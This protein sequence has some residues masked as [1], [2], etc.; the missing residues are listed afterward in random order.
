MNIFQYIQG[1]RKGKE[2]NHLEKE[3]MKDP[4]LAD[5]L[6]GFDSVKNETHASRIKKMRAN[7]SKQTGLK[8][9][10]AF[11]YWSAAATVLLIVGIGGYFLL[12]THQSIVAENVSH[13]PFDIYAPERVLIAQNELNIPLATAMQKNIDLLDETTV[14][15]YQTE[16]YSRKNPTAE[17]LT[18]AVSAAPQ[19]AERATSARMETKK[20]AE[21]QPVIG[22]KEYQKYLK[23][24]AVLPQSEGCKGKEGAVRLKFR[25][26]SEGRP[27]NIRV[28]QSLCPEADREAVR[29]VEQGADW[30]LSDREVEMDVRFR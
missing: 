22:E 18:R 14:S 5:A 30:T 4:F 15:D 21:P 25:I 19:Q 28:E 13:A 27:A 24:N 10:L 1:N 2:I 26:D 7:V 17:G 12:N 23:K 3:A 6:E 29:L 20:S 9:H 11:Q 8:K 16:N